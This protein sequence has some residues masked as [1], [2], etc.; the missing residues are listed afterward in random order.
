MLVDTLLV[1]LVLLQQGFKVRKFGRILALVNPADEILQS[2]PLQQRQFLL[3]LVR[4]ARI[5]AS[6]AAICWRL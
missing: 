6:A 3:K 5:Q 4:F 1:T 2:L